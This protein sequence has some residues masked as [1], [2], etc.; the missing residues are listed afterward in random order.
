MK[1][2][3]SKEFKASESPCCGSWTCRL[4]ALAS[5]LVSTELIPGMEAPARLVVRPSRRGSVSSESLESV[6]STSLSG[7]ASGAPETMTVAKE[8]RGRYFRKRILVYI[9]G[10]TTD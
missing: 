4:K 8:T 10:V 7:G 5:V 6:V 3:G 1:G 9:L 2:T